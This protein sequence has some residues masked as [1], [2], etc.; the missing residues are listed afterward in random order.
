[1]SLLLDKMSYMLDGVGEM[2][3]F[4]DEA[5]HTKRN[6]YGLLIGVLLEG[7]KMEEIVLGIIREFLD[8]DR[9]IYA[10]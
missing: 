2:F 8:K 6:Y 4:N 7:T 5:E 1:M 3:E 9:G 10:R